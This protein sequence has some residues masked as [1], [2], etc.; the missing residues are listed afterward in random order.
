MFLRCGIR[1]SFRQV[2]KP[3]AK[4]SVDTMA[5]ALVSVFAGTLCAMLTASDW[6]RVVMA[7]AHE[8]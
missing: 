2:R 1:M 4:K 6:L 7:E 5:M 8:S 3:Q